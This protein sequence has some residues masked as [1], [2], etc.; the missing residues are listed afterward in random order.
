M[1]NQQIK[2]SKC[3]HD[4]VVRP[5]VSQSMTWIPNYEIGIF[6]LNPQSISKSCCNHKKNTKIMVSK[7]VILVVTK[8]NRKLGLVVIFVKSFKHQH[9]KP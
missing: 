2:I 7:R 3:R 5:A 6:F 8:L 4:I 1:L 9:K